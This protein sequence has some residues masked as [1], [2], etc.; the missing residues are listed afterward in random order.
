MWGNSMD[1]IAKREF[2]FEHAR[3]QGYIDCLYKTLEFTF[4]A[5]IATVGIG[6]G[7]SDPSNQETFGVAV[8]AYVLPI[9][10]YVFGVM[11]AYNSYALAI[12]GKRAELLHSRMY[13]FS[14]QDVQFTNL[15]NKYV[16]ADRFLT[17]L[18]YGVPLGFYLTIPTVSIVYSIMKYSADGGVFMSIV[19]PL[20]ALVL[21]LLIMFVLIIH[22]INPHFSIAK[23]Q[24]KNRSKARKA[25]RR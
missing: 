13:R 3:C 4:A 2:D 9:C 25:K 20:C 1:E 12:C 16:L 23:I 18:A 10:I 11:Y 17:M 8:F 7:F 19:V 22:I 14:E 6:F 15:V 5:L 21:Y 24:R